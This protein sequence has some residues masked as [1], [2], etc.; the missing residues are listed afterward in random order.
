[1]GRK[2]GDTALAIC[3]NRFIVCTPRDYTTRNTYDE[4]IRYLVANGATE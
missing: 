4:I 1:M 2:N 3:K